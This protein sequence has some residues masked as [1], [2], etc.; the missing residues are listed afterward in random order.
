MDTIFALSTARGRAG[1]A[2]VRVSGPAAATAAAVLAGD[3]PPPR[4]ASLRTLSADGLVLDQAI[5]LNFAEGGSVTGEPVVEFHVHGSP[6]VVAALLRALGGLPGF[7]PAEPGE[8]TRRALLNG[9]LTLTEVEGLGDLLAA[10]TEMQRRQAMAALAG[11]LRGAAEGWRDRLLRAAALIEATIDFADEDVPVD[12]TSEVLRIIDAVI[13]AFGEALAGYGGAE[14]VRDGFTVA[15]VG[16]P[17]VGKSTLLNRLAGREAAITSAVA[18]TT[19]DVIEVKMDIAGLPVTVLDTAGIRDTAEPVEAIGVART[20]ERAAAADLR[21]LLA[22]DEPVPAGLAMRPDDIVLRAKADDDP[23][24]GEGISGATG[25]GVEHLLARIATILGAR[26]VP[27]ALIT[28]ERHRHAVLTAKGLLESARCR[29]SS[30]PE[31]AE[32][33]AEDLRGAI[34]ALEV[35]VGRVDVEAVLGEIFAQFCIGK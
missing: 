13:A 32:L 14:R 31:E 21:V 1:L 16:A 15:I 12:V 34:R 35:L 29:L 7:R 3:V 24:L 6:A 27:D 10:E 25:A 30:D 8:F 2:V 17:N 11:N 9:R 19:R 18:G 33:I 26:V 4:R 22:G 20:L 5:V 28:R 23:G